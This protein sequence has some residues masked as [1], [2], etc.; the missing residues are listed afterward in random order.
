MRAQ[1][2]L[3]QYKDEYTINGLC[4]GPLLLN[5]IRRI[6]RGIG[7]HTLEI[8]S[9]RGIVQTK[10]PQS[11]QQSR[12]KTTIANMFTITLAFTAN[13]CHGEQLSTQHCPELR[14]TTKTSCPKSHDKQVALNATHFMMVDPKT[15]HCW[16][17]TPRTIH[18][19][20]QSDTKKVSDTKDTVKSGSVTTSEVET[21]QVT[22]ANMVTSYA[23]FPEERIEPKFCY[24][25]DLLRLIMIL[26]QEP[27][28]PVKTTL[29]NQRKTPEDQLSNARSQL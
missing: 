25:N 28:H 23:R 17:I 13:I 16:R 6:V 29:K 11:S 5:I 4:C 26:K 22:T 18:H 3:F 27:P 14:L 21:A 19:P 7:Q 20:E 12:N 8:P 2:R 9:K 10:V 24:L 1:Q 15:V